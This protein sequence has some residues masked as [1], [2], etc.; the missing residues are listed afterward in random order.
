MIKD[1]LYTRDFPAL[2]YIIRTGMDDGARISG[3]LLWDSSYA[4]FKFRNDLWPDYNKEMV[5]Q[6][7]LDYTKRSRRMGK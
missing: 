7:L 6:D 1:Y 2:D 3:F 4:E 5:I